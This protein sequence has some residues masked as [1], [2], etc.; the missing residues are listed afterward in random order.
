MNFELWTLAIEELK[1]FHKSFNPTEIQITSWFRRLQNFGNDTLRLAVFGLTEG[2]A[3]PTYH[4]IK[5]AL[6]GAQGRINKQTRVP[7][8][9]GWA[10]LSQ[11]KLDHFNHH[12]ELLHK[13]KKI[14][15]SSERRIFADDLKKQW[16]NTYQQ[17]PNYR[18]R[19]EMQDLIDAK[20]WTELVRIGFLAEM[21]EGRVEIPRMQSEGKFYA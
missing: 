16:L 21:P 15:D 2:E 8:A 19:Q 6:I 20:N 18:T 12:I 7:E 9:Q 17:L 1:S 13:I 14:Q 5:Q 3:V 11:E 4:K 10:P